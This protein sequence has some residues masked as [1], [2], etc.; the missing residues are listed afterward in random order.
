M[1]DFGW[2]F[3]GWSGDLT[4]SAN[5][6][7]INFNADKTITATFTEG[8]TVTF[9]EGVNGY[10]GT[11]DTFIRQLAQTTDYSAATT[12]D[13]DGED[14]SAGQ[15]SIKLGLLRF[16]NIFGS[17]A[18]QIPA[19]ANIQS[20]TLQYV[21]TNTGDTGNVNEVLIDWPETVTYN[22][23]GSTAGVQ[24]EDYGASL[25]TASGTP[26][27]TKSLNVTSSLA[28]WSAN[29]SAN[30][31]WIFRPTANDGVQFSSSENGTSLNRPKLTVTY[32]TGPVNQAPDQ[33]ATPSP[34]DNATGVST[35]PTLQ[36]NVT[37]PESIRWTSLSMDAKPVEV[38]VRI[39]PSSFCRI[40][41]FIPRVIQPLSLLK[42]S[43]L[44]TMQPR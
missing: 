25:G 27:E 34:V 35:S 13:W 18:G 17:Q 39:S 37:D 44:R 12:V 42:P 31:G 38:R 4:G 41:N 23:F 9:Q 43:G 32:T 20:A 19:G 33:P 30:H 16:D 40:L 24:P 5:P 7:T 15:A 10:S 29:P 14:G 11:K 22:S 1:P 21:V 36:V 2:A 26:A 3:S 28:V 8:G 6:A